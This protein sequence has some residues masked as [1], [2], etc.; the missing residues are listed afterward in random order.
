MNRRREQFIRIAMARLMTRYPFEPQ[1]RATASKM[2][3]RWLERKRK[4]SKRAVKYEN[5]FNRIDKR[6]VSKK[7]QQDTN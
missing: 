6:L 5:T 4:I 7:T 2:Y 3:V 1:R